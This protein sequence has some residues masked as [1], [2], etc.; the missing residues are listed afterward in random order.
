MER[1]TRTMAPSNAAPQPLPHVLS[2]S[3]PPPCTLCPCLPS[4]GVLLLNQGPR[5]RLGPPETTSYPPP[6]TKSDPPLFHL[7]NLPW[8]VGRVGPGVG[9]GGSGLKTANP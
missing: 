3:Y 6:C 8:R 7:G 2:S 4:L 9:A 5:A 1:A